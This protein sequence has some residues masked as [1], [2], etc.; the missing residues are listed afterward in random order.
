MIVALLNQKGGVGKT[1]LATHLAGELSTG[2]KQVVVIDAD[3]QGSALDWAQKRSHGGWRRRFG[4]VGLARETLHEEVPELARRA[5]H[6]VIDGPPR[7][8]AL[9]R[10]AILAADLVLVPVQPSPYDVWASSEIVALVNEARLFKPRLKAAFIVN[11]CVVRTL[12]GREVRQA[13][14]QDTTPQAMPVLAST[15][16]QRVVF[17]EAAAL[18]QLVDEIDDA[19]PAG[20]EIA[21]FGDE[22]RG[23]LR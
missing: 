16:S 9:A 14:E 10:S 13:L 6:V 17:A 21:R 18:G 22:V 5:D 8:T 4:V 19:C 1:T 11:R 7:V 2:G 23:W 12:I 3:P 20:Q 15:V